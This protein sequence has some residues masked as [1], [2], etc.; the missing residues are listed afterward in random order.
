MRDKLKP[1]E[2]LLLGMLYTRISLFR[3]EFNIANEFANAFRRFMCLGSK[4]THLTC[5]NGKAFAMLSGTRCFDVSVQCKHARLF[6][7]RTD[8]ANEF[9]NLMTFLHEPIKSRR[10]DG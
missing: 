3:V 7:D 1:R 5:D 2:E 8:R 10:E 9:A 4:L 6:G